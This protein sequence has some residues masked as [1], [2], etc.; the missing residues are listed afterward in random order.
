MMG[1][2]PAMPGKPKTV[3]TTDIQSESR[4]KGKSTRATVCSNTVT[5]VKITPENDRR[6][7]DLTARDH[8]ARH[9][10][11]DPFHKGG[12]PRHESLGK[13]EGVLRNRKDRARNTDHA[14]EIHGDHKTRR[15][16]GALDDPE[17]ST[18]DQHAQEHGKAPRRVGCRL[19]N[20]PHK[21]LRKEI[22]IE[23]LQHLGSRKIFRMLG[24]IVPKLVGKCH[25]HPFRIDGI[26]RANGRSAYEKQQKGEQNRSRKSSFFHFKNPSINDISVSM[27]GKHK[28]RMMILAANS[29]LEAIVPTPQSR[30]TSAVVCARIP[31]P[32]DFRITE[33]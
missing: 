1:A 3:L 32:S 8:K 11:R 22:E 20:D 16:D 25:V 31:I 5:A 30:H 21:G 29:T 6:R 12:D 17:D 18:K 23:A 7:G 19:G 14:D 28:V 13:S 27:I 15:S 24:Q 33:E 10:R 2:N 9:G 26:R 4:I